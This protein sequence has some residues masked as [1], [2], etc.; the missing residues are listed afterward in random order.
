MR[1]M[2]EKKISIQAV[3]GFSLMLLAGCAS[4][5]TRSPATSPAVRTAF[6]KPA[7]GAVYSSDGTADDKLS[8]SK[9]S[10]DI[11]LPAF[12]VTRHNEDVFREND[13]DIPVI[14]EYGWD[15]RAGM[16]VQRV[17]NRDGS[18]RSERALPGQTL[19]FTDP[20]IELA[21]ALTREAPEL[22]VQ[23]SEPNLNFYA[24]FRYLDSGDVACG[25]GSR[26]LHVIV[27]GG[28]DGQRPIAHAIVDLMKRRMV[29]PFFT[30][31][32]PGPSKH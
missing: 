18:F 28:D 25:P 6:V 23:L 19:G 32:T 26:C 8:A 11:Q 24:G 31:D 2:M 29:H 30:P 14:V 5:V 27:S 9:A 3:L 4:Q 17:Y 13:Q 1:S 16:G 12:V 7:P 20:E 22:A 15:Y 21:F 10:A